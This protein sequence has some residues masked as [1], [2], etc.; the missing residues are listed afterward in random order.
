MHFVLLI[1]L[2][3]SPL[4]SELPLLISRLSLCPLERG[5]V[6]VNAREE[7]YVVAPA[8]RAACN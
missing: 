3:L 7:G 6:D 2:D 5:D 8:E 4:G 1:C